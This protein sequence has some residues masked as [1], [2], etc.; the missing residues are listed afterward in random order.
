MSTPTYIS[1]TFVCETCR[2]INR[3]TF[4]KPD[5]VRRPIEFDDLRSANAH[6]TENVDHFVEPRLRQH[7]LIEGIAE[8]LRR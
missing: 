6:V 2:L 1:L 3:E 4:A 7:D 8:G 5:F